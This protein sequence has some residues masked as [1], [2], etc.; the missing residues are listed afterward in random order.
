VPLTD[1][2]RRALAEIG[3][4]I[5]KRHGIPPAPERKQTMPWGECIR[6]PLDGLIATD[7]CTTAVWHGLRQVLASL[8]LLCLRLHGHAR[9]GTAITALH[10]A[11]RMLPKLGWFR[12]GH[13]AAARGG[14]LRR[15]SGWARLPLGGTGLGRASLSAYA[16]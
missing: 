10:K 15:E 11:C 4:K 3:R 1:G 16:P 2:D 7:F 5:L 13:A 12:P 9:G 8:L 14:G 6:I